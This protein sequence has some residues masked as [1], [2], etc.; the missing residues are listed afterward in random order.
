VAAADYDHIESVLQGHD[1]KWFV[2]SLT[3]CG[4]GRQEEILRHQRL[5][6]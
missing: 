4:M 1:I 3:D 5:R 6:R 2:D